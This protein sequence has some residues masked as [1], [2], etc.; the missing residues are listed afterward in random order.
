MKP[1]GPVTMTTNERRTARKG[2]RV[3]KRDVLPFTERV[4]AKAVEDVF[5]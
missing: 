4:R 2:L 1:E 5:S 3:A